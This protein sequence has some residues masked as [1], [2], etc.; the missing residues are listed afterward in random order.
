MGLSPVRPSQ[1]A[2]IVPAPGADACSIVADMI[3]GLGY[4]HQLVTWMINEDGTLTSDFLD[5]VGTSGGSTSGLS[6][7]QNVSATST[8]TDKVTIQWS[9]VAGASSYNVYRVTTNDASQ[10][11]TPLATVTSGTS[12]DDVPPS[13][14]TTYWYA[15]RAYSGTQI[16][17]LSSVVSGLQK[18][19]EAPASLTVNFTY[20]ADIQTY[21]IPS[22]YTAMEV[23]VASAGGRD[24]GNKVCAQILSGGCV[25]AYGPTYY[26]GGGG[27]SGSVYHVSGIAV[28][29]GDVFKIRV[30]K[31]TATSTGESVVWKT[32]EGSADYVISHPGGDGTS[33]NITVVGSP[34]SGGTS[35]STTLGGTP[36]GDSAAGTAG[37]GT[38]GGAAVTVDGVSSGA[39]NDGTN[40]YTVADGTPGYVRIVLT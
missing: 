35:G 27:G 1:T 9:S 38:T 34:G 40:N 39:G 28:A 14:D 15:V 26:N 19:A 16:S 33:G 22:G 4:L 37:S 21:T 2:A 8:L 24:G 7:P 30:G 3:T 25:R 32:T 5:A 29:A 10:M 6:A 17:N 11:T 36:E 13:K 31:K 12:Y 23:Y 18:T 20:S